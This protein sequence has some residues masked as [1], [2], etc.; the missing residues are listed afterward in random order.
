MKPGGSGGGA[1]TSFMNVN[2]VSLDSNDFSREGEKTIASVQRLI[3]SQNFADYQRLST[4]VGL[5]SGQATSQTQGNINFVTNRILLKQEAAKLGLYASSEVAAKFIED[6]MFRNAD[7]GF[8][9]KAYHAYIETLAN[10]G[11]KEKD[12]QQL[13]A[14]YIVFD[15]AFEVIGGGLAPSEKETLALLKS[16]QQTISLSTVSFQLADFKKDL[17]PTEEEIKIYWETTK[18]AY[19]TDRQLKITYAITNLDDS[20][21]P[22]RPTPT[23][24]ADPAATTQL[25]LDYQT[26][27]EAWNTS[28]KAQTK[29]LTKIFGDFSND[30][31]DSDFNGF[32]AAAAKAKAIAGADFN[33][34]TT[35]P[36]TA[37]TAPDEL[38]ALSLKHSGAKL[39]DTLFA[40]KVQN[41]L[42][43]DTKPYAIGRD[44]HILVSI[45]EQIM[46]STKSFEEAKELATAALITE[47]AEKAM[48]AAAEKAQTELAA[49]VTSGSTFEAAATEK[50]LTAVSHKALKKTAPQAQSATADFYR[51]AQTTAPKTVAS[52]LSSS[53]N[54]TSVVFVESRVFEVASDNA[55]Q[56]A[57]A[58]DSSAQNFKYSAFNAW[59][60]DLKE[61]KDLQLPLAN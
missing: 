47:Q 11:L 39:I 10:L 36:F 26:K 22:K 13:V 24:D 57:R 60:I 29:I 6:E 21:E 8:D 5:L 9:A 59:L 43:F 7:G 2:G 34:A 42:R 12:F 32:E 52:D 41:D 31:E 1:G 23:A 25:N 56:E 27:L 54:S 28:R 16:E 61:G 51:I 58:L 44:G 45:V 49:L 38:K 40:V 33:F 35:E 30:L 19:K 4:F 20:D 55:T 53:D 48:T 14:E 50:G 17:V 18:D 37:E 3:Y 15:K 46:P